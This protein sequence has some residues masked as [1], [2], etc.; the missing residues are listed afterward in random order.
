M[1]LVRGKDTGPERIVAGLLRRMGKKYS[2]HADNLPGK[3]DLYFPGKKKAIFVHGC[4]WHR[5]T[6]ARGRLP[7]SRRIFWET[8]LESNRRRDLRVRAALRAAQWETLVV[9]ECQLRR[10]EVVDRRIKKFISCE[11]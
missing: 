10:P 2:T 11:A 4:F 7:K 9:W 5:H 3:P 1:S 6:C 8:K